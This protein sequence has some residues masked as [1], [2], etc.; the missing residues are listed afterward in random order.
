MKSLKSWLEF[1]RAWYFRCGVI[2]LMI[3]LQWLILKPYSHSSSIFVF[4]VSILS[5]GIAKIMYDKEV[6]IERLKH[7]L[8]MHSVNYKDIIDNGNE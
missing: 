5:I 3:V 6:T 7:R 4:T 2:V 1:I 8:D